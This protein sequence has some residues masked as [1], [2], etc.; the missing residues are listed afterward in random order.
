VTS[1]GLPP[2]LSLNPSNG[3]ISGIPTQT[4]LFSFTLSV[5]DQ[6]PQFD[7]QSFRI[8]INP[9]APPTISGPE[10]LPSGVVNQ[11]YPNTT[12]TASGGT[13]PY[14]WDPVVSPAL[15]NGLSW[16]A[17]T[18]TI[19]GIPLNGSQ[20]TTSHKFT[21]RDSTVPFLTG[22]RTYSLTIVLP[23]PPTITTTS[24]PNATVGTPYSQPVLATG[25]VGT[26]TWTI[27]AGSL[28]PGLDINQATGE[29]FGTPISAGLANFTVQVTDTFPQSATQSFS[30]EIFN[31]G[32]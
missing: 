15:P 20:G 24:L 2:E 11:A 4:G 6:I 27:S 9:P 17:T 31:S 12:L 30:I 5:T 28:P 18:Q 21:V 8:T 16:D 25:G 1:G 26:L 29:I 3:N 14:T 23:A 19:S 13:A 22:T 10:S 32:P 7:E